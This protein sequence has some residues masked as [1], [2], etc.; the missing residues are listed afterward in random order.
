MSGSRAFNLAVV[1]SLTLAAAC[2][3]P[4]EVQI[5][6]EEDG[7]TARTASSILGRIAFLDECASCHASR[8]GFDLAFFSF[9]DSTIIRRAVAHVDTLTAFDITAYINSLNTEHVDRHAQSFQPGGYEVMGDLAFAQNL[10]G[11]D[12]WPGDL[13]SDELA[14]IDPLD[15]PV[16]FSFP[17]WSFEGNNLDWMPDT[18]L[19]EPILDF[20]EGA[21]GR[22]LDH[23]YRVGTDQALIQVVYGLRVADRSADFTVAPCLTE[24]PVRFQPAECFEVRRWTSSLVAQHMLRK[25][26]VEPIDPMVHDVWWDVGNAARKSIQHGMAIPNAEE[27]WATWM[28][29]GWAFE[30]ERHASVYLSTGL[31]RQ[32]LWRHGVFSA[33]RS[34][35]VRP[36]N[37]GDAY[38]DL[39]T[40]VNLAPGHWIEDVA[41]FGF[42]E[43]IARLERGDVPDAT[44]FRNVREGMPES[45]MAIAVD[46]HERTR[47]LLQRRLGWERASAL[48]PLWERVEELL[49]G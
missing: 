44:P 47:L 27:N 5:L 31:A 14:A 48:A 40:A 20:G 39:S 10:F 17:R 15:V 23:Y 42:N 25:G 21:I 12:E 32:G 13:T 29:L 45:Q 1:L 33:L 16:A 8:D 18:P 38:K 46:G 37:R 49:D 22:A 6:D 35:V 2:E 7:A 26:V 24:D 11:A 43:L 28:Y 41:T 19:P 9:P 30:P 34:Q 3:T 36:E 4:S